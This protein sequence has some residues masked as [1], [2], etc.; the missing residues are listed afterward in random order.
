MKGDVLKLYN[1]GIPAQ[2]E[3]KKES[4]FFP[5]QKKWKQMFP[6]LGS[7]T[8]KHKMWSEEGSPGE[9]RGDSN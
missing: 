5:S 1:Q 2:K 8:N 9:E 6:Q 3:K 4:I 7:I